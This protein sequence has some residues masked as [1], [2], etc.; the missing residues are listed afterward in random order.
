MMYV[1]TLTVLA[2]D[3]RGWQRILKAAYVVL[4]LLQSNKIEVE[5]VDRGLDHGVWASFKVA[6]DPEENPLNVPLE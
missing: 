1:W 4:D 5:A 2:A 6:F 3:L